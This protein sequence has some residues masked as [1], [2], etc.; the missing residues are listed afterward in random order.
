[1]GSG[2]LE[3]GE[4]FE[5]LESPG[6]RDFLPDYIVT[7][8]VPLVLALILCLLLSYIMCG[9]REGVYVLNCTAH[10][11]ILC[12]AINYKKMIIFFLQ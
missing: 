6:D 1:M 4:N 12:G 8:I 5:P 10:I 2:V 9:R 7:V 3:A 11:D